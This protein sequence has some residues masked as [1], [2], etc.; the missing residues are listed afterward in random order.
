M[1][2][3]SISPLLSLPSLSSLPSLLSFSPLPPSLYSFL[4][5]IKSGFVAMA[6]F[7]LVC[8]QGWILLLSLTNAGIACVR[9]HAWLPFWFFEMV[10]LCCPGWP[11][12]GSPAQPPPHFQM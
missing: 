5:E 7:N 9:P 12:S 4:S 2:L 1:E 6:S 11:L 3:A 10:L 8:R